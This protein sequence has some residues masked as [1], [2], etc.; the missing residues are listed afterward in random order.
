MRKPEIER[1]GLKASAGGLGAVEDLDSVAERIRKHDQ[2]LD[3]A[4][5]GERAG[6]AR[7]LHPGLLE[8]RGEALQRGRVCDLPAVEADALAAVLAHDYPLLAIVHPQRQALGAAIGQLH[9]EKLGAEARPVLERFGANADIS[10][11]LNVHRRPPSL[12]R[13]CGRIWAFGARLAIPPMCAGR[14]RN[15]HRACSKAGLPPERMVETPSG[16]AADRSICHGF[17]HGLIFLS[18]ARVESS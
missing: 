12:A 10:E 16:P 1:P 8:S 9:A 17:R 13:C 7:H 4:L 5:V 6:A 15:G 2:V 3:P 18:A 11:T 14:G